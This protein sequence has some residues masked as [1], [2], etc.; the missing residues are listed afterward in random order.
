[1]GEHAVVADVGGDRPALAVGPGQGSGGLLDRGEEVAE[2][3]ELVGGGHGRVVTSRGGGVDRPTRPRGARGADRQPSAA[4]M[5]PS[6]SVRRRCHRRASTCT[7]VQSRA[8]STPGW[9]TWVSKTSWG[10][11]PSSQITAT[12]YRD[13][14]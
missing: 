2:A 5:S 8:E 13:G 4:V 9:C 11:R 1:E 10:A 6:T 14:S 3:A 12:L 7:T